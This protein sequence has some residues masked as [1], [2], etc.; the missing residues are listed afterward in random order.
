[1]VGY[2]R[3]VEDPPTYFWCHDD[4]PFRT[5][6]ESERATEIRLHGAFEILTEADLD[7]Q[8]LAP[9]LSPRMEI[10]GGL[11]VVREIESWHAYQAFNLT[12]RKQRRP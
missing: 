5:Y 3:I 10:D 1:M 11:L 2:Y 12:Q 8:G 7:D 9:S 6:E 4:V